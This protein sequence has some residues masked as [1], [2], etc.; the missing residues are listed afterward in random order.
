MKSLENDVDL[1]SLTNKKIGFAISERS[2]QSLIIIANKMKHFFIPYI[3]YQ[4]LVIL[5]RRTSK[6]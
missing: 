5:M 6:E 4:P 2:H 1:T 3:V